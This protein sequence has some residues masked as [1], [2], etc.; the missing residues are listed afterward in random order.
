MFV[1]LGLL[2]SMYVSQCGIVREL[3]SFSSSE[4]HCV[5]W[6]AIRKKNTFRVV[7]LIDDNVLNE[8]Q[9]LEAFS[10]Y[11]RENVYPIVSKLLHKG[12]DPL[13]KM[14]R[15][16]LGTSNNPLWRVKKSMRSFI[17]QEKEN[18]LKAQDQKAEKRVW[19]S[20]RLLFIA[21]AKENPFTTP[22][23]ML[24]RDMI[25]VIGCLVQREQLRPRKKVWDQWEQDKLK[26][27]PW[28]KAGHKK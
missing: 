23:A 26:F 1:I 3:D 14:V 24:P 21:S 2:L 6:K 22:I 12:V 18:T 19:K 8:Q 15:P 11:A 17:V 25:N 10:Y 9:K 5:L 13:M 27:C 4:E 7:A 16:L 20:I 28:L